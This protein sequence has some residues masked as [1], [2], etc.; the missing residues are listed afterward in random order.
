MVLPLELLEMNWKFWTTPPPLWRPL[1]RPSD[2]LAQRCCSLMSIIYRSVPH[3]AQRRRSV[4]VHAVRTCQ[5]SRT[6][7]GLKLCPS[8]PKVSNRSV[9]NWN[10]IKMWKRETNLDLILQDPIEEFGHVLATEW[11]VVLFGEMMVK[12]GGVDHHQTWHGQRG[13]GYWIHQIRRSSPTEKEF[14]AIRFWPNKHFIRQ[15]PHFTVENFF[16]PQ[17]CRF[18]WSKLTRGRCAGVPE[19]NLPTLLCN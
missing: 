4:V 1:P 16:V 9:Q 5:H 10:D 3:S 2:A 12:T 7:V 17:I 19:R 6:A 11:L 8:W 13:H 18:I 15:V 14:P